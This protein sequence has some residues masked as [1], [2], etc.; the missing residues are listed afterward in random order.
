MKLVIFDLDDTLVNFAATR[1]VAYRCL[2][3]VVEREGIDP[4]AFIRACS[5]VDRPLFSLFEQGQ[6]TRQQYRTRRFGDPFS[7]IGLPARDDLVVQLNTVF[8]ECVNDRPLLYDDV[9]P[10]LQTLR[11]RG[12]RTA[13]LTNG[14]SD[15]QRRK[16]KATGLDQAVDHVAIG[17]EIGFSKPSALAFHAVV[18]RFSL[19]HADALMVGDSPELDYDGALRAGLEAL[20]LDRDGNFQAAHRASIRSLDDVLSR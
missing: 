2:A 15:G 5:E 17:E 19:R 14:P 4:V 13:I 10:V 12:L 6:L 3:E 11:A 16:L 1:Q 9:R 18:D 20:L 7:R 8:M